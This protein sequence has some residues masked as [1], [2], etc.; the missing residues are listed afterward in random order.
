MI[1][2]TMIYSGEGLSLTM[3]AEGCK[4]TAYQDS[5]GVWTVGYG[6]T[7]IDVYRG[8]VITADKARELLLSDIAVAVSDV[9][10]LVTYQGLTQ[11][12]FD[13]LVDFTYNL[14]YGNFASSTLLK[15]VNLDD[16]QDA[17]LQFDRWDLCNGR[18]LG[19]LLTRRKNEANEFLE[20]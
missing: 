8:L 16:M 13:A 14:G 15:L 9:N 20:T 5:G 11:H 2:K 6:H 18:V 1:I 7:G 17:A 3:A 4:L 12:E 10:R 19:G